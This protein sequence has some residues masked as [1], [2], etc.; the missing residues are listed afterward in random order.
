MHLWA[1]IFALPVC[2]YIN[3]KILGTMFI[4]CSFVIPHR[5][6]QFTYWDIMCMV[7]FESWR[8]FFLSRDFI[9]TF[10]NLRY[11]HLYTLYT[12]LSLRFEISTSHSRIQVCK[13]GLSCTT[14][15]KKF[16]FLAEESEP[17]VIIIISSTFFVKIQ[18]GKY[19]TLP[20]A[21][22]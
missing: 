17:Y 20:A 14:R 18:Y 5:C 11:S 8:F 15:E 9:S 22:N 2:H 12:I 13:T 19:G 3:G 4:P 7:L 16:T 10:K 21:G 6:L 1:V